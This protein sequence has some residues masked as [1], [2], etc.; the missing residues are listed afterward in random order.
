L[1]VAR[2]GAVSSQAAPIGSDE[3]PEP[4]GL[5]LASAPIDATDQFLYHKTTHRAVY[6]AAWAGCHTAE[7]RLKPV[8]DV[9][10]YNQRGEITETTLGNIVVRCGKDHW[11]PPLSCGLLPGTYRARLLAEGKI[12]ERV[13]PLSV[14]DKCDELVFINSVRGWRRAQLVGPRDAR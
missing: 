8:D 2:D 1:L 13:L 12:H 10:L 14:L 7:F 5:A 6:A 9:L 3:F 11:T 4:V